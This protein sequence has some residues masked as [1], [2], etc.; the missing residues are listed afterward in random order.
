MI[1]EEIR[2]RD[3]TPDDLVHDAVRRRAVPRAPARAR[4]RRVRRRRS[5]RCTRDAIAEYHARALPA[6]R[7]SWSRPPATSTTTT[8]SSWSSAA[9]ADR[10]RHA[11]AAGRRVADAGDPSAFARVERPL[12]QAHLVLGVRALRARRSRPLRARRRRPGARRRHELAAVPGGAREARPR[13]LG[14][15]VPQRVRGDRRRSAVYCGTAP[16]RVD[17]TLDVVRGELDRLVADGG[18]TERELDAAPRATSPARWRCR[19]RA[20]RAG[21]TASAAAELTHRRGPEPRRGGRARSRRSPPTTSPGS[22]TGCSAAGS[23]TLAVG[24]SRR[25]RRLA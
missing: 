3:D 24:R 1:L 25:R 18:V 6:R 4:D 22:S 13:V 11:P 17:E 7:T 8:S 16:E 19:S 2:M 12:E 14:V 20:R 21:C 10:R 15:L 9:L 5:P 23:R